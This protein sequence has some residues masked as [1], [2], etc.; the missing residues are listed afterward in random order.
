MF[1]CFTIDKLQLNNIELEISH[2]N[3]RYQTKAYNLA[4]ISETHYQ[5]VNINQN[6][7]K[8]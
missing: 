4:N 8:D 6:L 1:V 3:I 7:L 5:S 2:R